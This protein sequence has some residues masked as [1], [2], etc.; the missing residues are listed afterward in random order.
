MSLGAGASKVKGPAAQKGSLTLEITMETKR[1]LTTQHRHTEEKFSG[2][3]YY[4]PY[5]PSQR[6]GGVG[7]KRADI[8]ISD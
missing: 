2:I 3:P 1:A 5:L 7:A 6:E 4:N 8:T